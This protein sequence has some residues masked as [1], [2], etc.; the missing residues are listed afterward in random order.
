M[1]AET[2]RHHDSQGDL[3]Q[4]EERH[5]ALFKAI[6]GAYTGLDWA[7]C[8]NANLVKDYHG[9]AYG[10]G[11]G[12]E[13]PVNKLNQAIDVWTML[14]AANNPHVSCRTTHETLRP[15]ARHFEQALNHM[16]VEIHLAETIRR[17]VLDAFFLM[18]VVKVHLKDSAPVQFEN[19]LWM[20]P[21]TPFASN[22]SLDDFVYDGDDQS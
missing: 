18:G 8:L 9:P 5:L 3:P 11:N 15:F 17:W 14:V 22:V 13:R 12:K 21:G 20:D 7:R 16:V 10:T 4:A 6:E 1:E 19:D 2:V